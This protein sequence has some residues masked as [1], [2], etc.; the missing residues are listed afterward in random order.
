MQG[1][2]SASQVVQMLLW[3]KTGRQKQVILSR[4]PHDAV[5]RSH[6]GIFHRLAGCIRAASCVVD[7]EAPVVST[8]GNART[9]HGREPSTLDNALVI[10]VPPDH[11]QSTRI[12]LKPRYGNR[13]VLGTRHQLITRDVHAEDPSAME[14]VH[15]HDLF[16]FATGTLIQIPELDHAVVRGTQQHIC[17]ACRAQSE[18]ET[19][20]PPTMRSE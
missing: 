4:M 11:S 19:R 7:A 18:T 13:R 9:I 15:A 12:R 16:R 17:T 10:F 5:D 2:R 6:V 20:D 3:V 8:R 14:I 1:R